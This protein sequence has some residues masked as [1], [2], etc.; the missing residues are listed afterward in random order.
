MTL[1]STRTLVGLVATALVAIAIAGLA[2]FSTASPRSQFSAT[3]DNPW[4][5]LKPGTT[6][7]FKHVEDGKQQREVFKVTHRTKIVRG[8]RCIV[9]DDRLY[10]GTHLYERTSDYYTQDRRGNVWYFGEDTALLDSKGRVTSREG[11]WHGGV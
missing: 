11:R 7:V 8:A 3:V 4:Y 5:P 6:L 9:I 2:A 1:R 10:T